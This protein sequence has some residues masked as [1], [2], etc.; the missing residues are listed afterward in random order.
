MLAP[1]RGRRVIAKLVLQ[2]FADSAQAGARRRRRWL[3]QVRQPSDPA[4]DM[5]LKNRRVRLIDRDMVGA[6]RAEEGSRD[7]AE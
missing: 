5:A 3:V 4:P 7:L 6:R 1:R 2:P